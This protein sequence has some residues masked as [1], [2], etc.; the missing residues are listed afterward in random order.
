MSQCLF[1]GDEVSDAG[2]VYAVDAH[3]LLIEG[4]EVRDFDLNGP[5]GSAY[6]RPIRVEGS[7]PGHEGRVQITGNTVHQWGPTGLLLGLERSCIFGNQHNGLLISGN[8]ME[9]TQVGEPRGVFLV[10]CE[11]ARITDNQFTNFDGASARAT[12]LLSS[13]R[14]TIQ[15]NTYYN[16]KQAVAVGT[17]G[18]GYHAITGN[19]IDG[20]GLAENAQGVIE[21]NQ[22]R[23]TC[24][25]NTIHNYSG[26]YLAINLRQAEQVI[27]GN[28]TDASNI[29]RNGTTGHTGYFGVPA[30][31]VQSVNGGFFYV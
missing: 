1:E 15:G 10:G 5:V 19:T 2:A 27:I 4:N 14:C 31:Q 18:V 29:Q 3:R 30:S 11:A 23:N 24:S 25:D 26:V 6:C 13:T 22:L 28:R 17:S 8:Q 12:Y 9:S 20:N 7:A 16:C 21:L